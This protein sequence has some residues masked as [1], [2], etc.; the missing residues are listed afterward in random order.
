MQINKPLD[1]DARFLL[2]CAES[3]VDDAERNAKSA[4][5]DL[6]RVLSCPDPDLTRSDAEVFRLAISR[7]EGVINT[8]DAVKAEL[9][10]TELSKVPREPAPLPF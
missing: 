1:Q 3:D 10:K 7:L 4:I 9:G 5:D 2:G 6:R 8:L